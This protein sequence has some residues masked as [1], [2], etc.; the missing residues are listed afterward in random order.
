MG[1]EN[2]ANFDSILE[3]EE[4]SAQISSISHSNN[5]IYNVGGGN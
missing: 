3:A 2:E 5:P 1:F 4:N